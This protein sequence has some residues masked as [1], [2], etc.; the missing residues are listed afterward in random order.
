MTK[1]LCKLESGRD[2]VITAEDDMSAA[3]EATE[4]ARWFDDYLVAL[5]NGVLLNVYLQSYLNQ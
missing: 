4:E 2:F 3:Y 1:Y 5:T